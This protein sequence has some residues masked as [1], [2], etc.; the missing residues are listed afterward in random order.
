MGQC[1]SRR[2]EPSERHGENTDISRQSGRA[3][4]K[5]HIDTKE[6]AGQSAGIQTDCLIERAESTK[7]SGRPH[8]V[9]LPIEDTASKEGGGATGM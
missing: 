2:R 1:F 5:R 9:G 8:E 4:A 3:R 6:V 7:P